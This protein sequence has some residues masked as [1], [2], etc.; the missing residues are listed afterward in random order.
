MK[1]HALTFALLACITALHAENGTSSQ[2]SQPAGNQVRL[3]LQEQYDH[4]RLILEHRLALEAE[5]EKLNRG[6]I[7]NT[8]VLQSV[9]QRW[10][11]ESDL[12]TA[13]RSLHINQR[14]A[15][16]PQIRALISEIN[17]FDTIRL[18]CRCE[19]YPDIDNDAIHSI[20]NDSKLANLILGLNQAKSKK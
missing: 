13:L 20:F 6:L 8:G 7:A 4:C 18:H 15:A 5:L 12:C 3:T 9:C 14:A 11:E 2:S 19:M 10:G 1:L 17:F 16:D